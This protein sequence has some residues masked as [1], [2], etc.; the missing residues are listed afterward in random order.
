MSLWCFMLIGQA[1]LI[2]QNFFKIHKI[3]GRFS[4]ILVP[5]ILISGFNTAHASLFGEVVHDGLYY[6]T[7]ALMF[8][9]LVFFGVLYGFAIYNIRKPLI[10]ARYMVCTL[11]PMFTPL[12]DRLIYRNFPSMVSFLPALRGVPMVWLYGFG[13]ANLMLVSLAIWDWQ[14]K[15]RYKVFIYVLG[16]NI[17]YDLS[18]ISFFKFSFW[19]RISDWIMSLPLS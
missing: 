18:V 17:I 16:L 14:S 12:T 3:L 4:Y 13:L 11:F 19:Q 10:H 8:N 6:S 9:S 15:N 5:L 1:F 7:I 2:R